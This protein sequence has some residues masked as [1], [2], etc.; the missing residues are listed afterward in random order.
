MFNHKGLI[1]GGVIVL[2]GV[3]W[4]VLGSGSSSQSD[5]TTT[6]TDSA[7]SGPGAQIVATLVSLQA[8]S[9]NSSIFS[10]PAFAS[11][12]DLTTAIVPE[13]VG[14]PDPFAPLA[15]ASVPATQLTPVSP[16]LFKSK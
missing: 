11:L 6:T 16:T 8:V 2:I 5:I 14:R 12:Q 7:L 4:Y 1:I 10:D 13:P 9:L 15:G 3:A